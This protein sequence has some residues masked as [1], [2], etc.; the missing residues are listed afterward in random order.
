MAMLLGNCL[1]E[2]ERPACDLY[3]VVHELLFF[4]NHFK[5]NG[6]HFLLYH[7]L[8]L[9]PSLY[10][11]GSNVG[12]FRHR[13]CQEASILR[14]SSQ[15]ASQSH[16][17]WIVASPEPFHLQDGGGQV[18]HV[19]F[20]WFILTSSLAAWHLVCAWG[21]RRARCQS[22]SFKGHLPGALVGRR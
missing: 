19:V 4:P 8:L 20:Q 14:Q 2:L 5:G 3:H 16:G 11:R 7:I 10:V 1:E 13:G 18:H 6:W 15:R 17:Q 21:G 12:H 22:I 9:L